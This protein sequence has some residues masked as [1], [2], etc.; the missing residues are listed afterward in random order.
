MTNEAVGE[1]PLF[2]VAAGN[3][4]EREIDDLRRIQAPSD[5]ANGISVGA[6]AFDEDDNE[7]PAEYSCIG[8]DREGCKI[9][10]DVL[11]FGG[12]EES[13]F[14]TLNGNKG[15]A[16]CERQGTS[17]ACPNLVRKIG[18]MMLLSGQVTP[19][20]ARAL[21]IHKAQRRLEVEDER[22]IG[23]GLLQQDAEDILQCTDKAVDFYYQ[24]KIRAGSSLHVPIFVPNLNGYNGNV[25]ITWT[26]VTVSS[27]NIGD[28]SAYT[29]N[30]LLEIFYPNKYKYRFSKWVDGN[31]KTV[32]IDTSS[33]IG[34]SEATRLQREGYKI[35]TMPV[36]KPPKMFHTEKELKKQDLKWDTV[37]KYSTTMR[38]SSL[39]DPAVVLQSIGR[40]D[41]ENED[42][43]YYMVVTVS[44]PKYPDDLYLDTCAQYQL[45]ESIQIRNT[46]EIMVPVN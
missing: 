24:G 17:F 8:P 31:E 20:L 21:I 10:P 22:M 11:E 14:G 36:S 27:T 9:K 34:Q 35:S 5:I 45:L 7:I 28:C 19:Q 25:Q 32:I 18:K 44:I 33:A 1:K 26:I 15:G 37:V 42:L 3:W 4:G 6:Y 41:G 43:A 29:N 38:G 23:N 46:A 12:N 40:E 16:Y 2:C 30:C 39:K 13:R